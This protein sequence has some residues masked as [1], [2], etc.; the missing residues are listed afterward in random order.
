[1][2]LM[3]FRKP[4][5]TQIQGQSAINRIVQTQIPQHKKN[6]QRIR[7]PLYMIT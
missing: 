3:Y 5:Q 7:A 2:L 4:S 6:P 1:M